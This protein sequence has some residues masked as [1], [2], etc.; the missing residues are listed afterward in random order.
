MERTELLDPMKVYII[1]AIQEQ[2]GHRALE[3][4]ALLIQYRYLRME[5]K[6]LLHQHPI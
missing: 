2:V 1:Q 3:Q 5:Q 6:E 4:L